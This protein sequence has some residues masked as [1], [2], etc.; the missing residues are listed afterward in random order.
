[1]GTH[2]CRAAAEGALMR[3]EASRGARSMN[4]V[5]LWELESES[6]SITKVTYQ[7]FEGGLKSGA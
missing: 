4:I 3:N 7:N 1:M 6:R 2:I 5:I